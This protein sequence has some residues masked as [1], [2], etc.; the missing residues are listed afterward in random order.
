M[1]RRSL[2]LAL[3][4]FLVACSSA[5]KTSDAAWTTGTAPTMDQVM[6][7]Q[8][9]EMAR[10]IPCG[11]QPA[12][13]VETCV[14]DLTADNPCAS[15]LRALDACTLAAGTAAVMCNPTYNRIVIRPGYCDSEF[16]VYKTCAQGG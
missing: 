3:A 10:T 9:C 14:N 6:C 8:L 2:K 1:S 16:A 5:K 13:C 11:E 4:F 15:Q 12:D 7:T